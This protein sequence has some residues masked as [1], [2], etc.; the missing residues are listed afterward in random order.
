[1]VI[2]LNRNLLFILFMVPT[3]L[4]AQVTVRDTTIIWHT[5]RYGLNA[6]H[7][8]N[9]N[10][11]VSFD[12]VAKIFTGVV[13]ENEYLKITLVPEFGGRIIS[14][15]YKPTGHEELYQNPAG[16]PYGVGQDWFYYKWLMVYGG[17]FPTLPEPEHGKAWLL[18]WKYTVLKQTP[19]TVRCQMSWVD[20]IKL[21]GIN[22]SKWRYGQ[23]NL[24]CDFSVTL[25][26]GASSLEADVALYN[27]SNKNLDYEYWTCLTLAPGSEPG[28]PKCTQGDE[29]II[30]ASKIK[31]SSGYP[32][33]AR[34]EKQVQGENGIYIF[35]KLRYWKNWS[36]DGI[37]YPWEDSNENYWGVINHDNEEGIIRVA[38]NNITTGIKIWAWGY[39]QSQNIKPFSSPSEVHR[40]YVELWAGHSNEFFAPAQIAMNSTKKWKEIYVP[41]IGLSNVTKANGEVIADFKVDDGKTVNLGFVTTRPKNRFNVS[42]GITGQHSQVLKTQTLM[43]DPVNGNRIMTDLPANQTWSSGDSLVCMISDSANGCY[44]ATSI[45]LDKITTEVTDRSAIAKD[46]QLYQNFP[47]PFNPSTSFKYQTAKASFVSIKIYNVLGREVATLVNEVKH[48]GS[49]SATWNA[50]GFG[51]GIY[52]CK[53]Q[54]GSFTSTKKMIL[55]K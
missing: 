13:L 46:F 37:A 50:A 6:D 7:T 8:M 26:K 31:I 18:P 4:M 35:D 2:S 22:T 45:P 38:D 47:N 10:T 34:Q 3:L 54:S 41:T 21:Q 51:S 32:D 23:T 27:D 42:I 5:F 40:P 29:I 24:R 28:D 43:P 48:I 44:L 36:N 53:M 9:W 16:A 33:I 11:N 14:M 20:S 39:P 55:I 12:T 1:M 17:I 49:Y 19:D 52:I 30:P 15:I 25:I